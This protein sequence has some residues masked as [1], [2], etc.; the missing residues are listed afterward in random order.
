MTTR[1]RIE[2]SDQVQYIIDTFQS[3]PDS[4]EGDR[5]LELILEG[6]EPWKLPLTERKL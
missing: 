2:N 6:V 1:K 4:P 3:I 5:H